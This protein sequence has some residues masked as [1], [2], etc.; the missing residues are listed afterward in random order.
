MQCFFYITNSYQP[1]DQVFAVPDLYMPDPALVPDLNFDRKIHKTCTFVTGVSAPPN[2][3]D[4]L[5]A[6]GQ[7]LNVEPC[8]ARNQ[9]CYA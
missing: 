5:R 6:G 3:F 8:T 2:Q 4:Q 1:Y 9:K 7:M